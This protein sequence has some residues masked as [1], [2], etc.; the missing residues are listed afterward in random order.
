MPIG[1]YAV[2]ILLGLALLVAVLLLV[3][4][5]IF[6]FAEARDDR[7]YPVIAAAEVDDGPR[8]VEIVLNDSHGLLGEVVRDERVGFTVIVAPVPG[9]EGFT[10]VGAWSPVN[11]CP[12]VIAADR[13][14]DCADVAWTWAGVPLDAADP[15]LQAFPTDERNGAVV[16]DF[17]AP[18]EPGAI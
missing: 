15:P 6:T 10:A 1:R 11:D 16:V 18:G 4:P 17:T 13:L 8:A 3:R 5:F 2:T 12:V 7:N 9:G 14:R